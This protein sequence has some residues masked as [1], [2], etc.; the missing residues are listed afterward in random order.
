MSITGFSV[1]K[2]TTVFVLTIFV[3]IMGLISYFSMPRESAPDVKIPFMIVTTVYPGVAPADIENLITRRIE[4][5]LKGLSGVKEINSSSSESFSMI[6]IEFEPDVNLDVAL[7]KVKDKVDRA[8]PDLP[9]DAEDPIVTE[10]NIENFP[11]MTVN[12]TADYDL[13]KLRKV[14]KDLSDEFIT[15]P[16]VLDA[17]VS[18][19][20]EREVQINIDPERLKDYNLGLQDVTKTIINEHLTMPAGTMNIGDYGYTVRVPGELKDPEKFR[21]LVVKATKDGPVYI[22]DVADVRYGFKDLTTIARLDGK[23]CISINITKRSGENIININKEVN[24]ILKERGVSFPKGTH[25]TIQNDRSKEIKIMVADLENNIITGFILVVLCIFLFLGVTN[26]IFIG[27]AIPLSMLITFSVLQWMGITLN[28]IVLFSLVLAVGM[29]VDDAVVIVENIYRHRQNGQGKNESAVNATDE[30]F[31]AV[32][33]STVTTLVAFLPLLFWPGIIGEFMF[34]LPLTL[35]IALSAS[36]FVAFVMNPVFCAKFMKI[37]PKADNPFDP[38]STGLYARFL[39]RYEQLITH[40][41]HFPKTTLTLATFSL[42]LT[43]VLY[44]FYGHGVEFFPETDP[45]QLYIDIK[46]PIGQR[47]EATDAVTKQL[48]PVSK[49]FPD[50]T[51]VLADVGVST[52]ASG[53]SSGSGNPSNEARI[54]IDFADFDY[55][56]QH[57]LKTFNEAK[58]KI[59]FLAG[60]EVTLNKPEEGPPVGQAIDLRIS[61]D[62][63]L[64]LGD[65]A[66]DIRSKIKNVPGLVDLKD[67][68]ESSKPEIRVK[69]DREKAA[70]LELSTMDVAGAVRTAINGSEVSKYRVEE[71]EYDITVRFEEKYRKSIP[72]MDKIYVFKEGRQIPLSSVASFEPTAGFGTIHRTQ[73]KRVVDVTGQ[74]LGRLPNDIIIDIRK[75]LAN[76]E[77]PPGYGIA[78]AGADE[79]QR[80]AQAFLSKALLIAL[81]LITMVLV[82]HFDSIRIPLIIMSGV[83][84][85]FQG[86]MI[87]LLVHHMPFGVIMTGIGVISL[88]GVVVKNAIVILDFAERLRREGRSRAQAIIEAGKFRLRP[89]ILTALCT[90][91]GLI[92]MATGWSYDFHTF[93]FSVNGA[94]SQWWAPMAIAV[95]YGLG[96]STILTLV[97]VPSMYV[98]YT[99][100]GKAGA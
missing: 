2:S 67:D 57:T 90:I 92:P 71:D 49:A 37:N 94:S 86:V 9:P 44:G 5:E 41:V 31:M 55:R 74:N 59:Q 40:A 24:R 63:Y 88:A 82:G 81:F 43:F 12:L 25:V 7:Q 36:L 33:S 51:H 68:F 75:I 8:K 85:S 50:V 27:I 78:Y 70:I 93:T 62:D 77:L 73:L 61:G 98:L 65:I 96:V 48:E 39:R 53:L 52:G 58:G 4:K 32:T 29:L 23:P 3:V 30:V 21:D 11:I 34:Y 72:D 1:K 47:I 54:Y 87:G 18:G 19:D 28:F 15:I 69:V 80:K 99:K 22:R 64:L 35:I 14:A 100:D 17:I 97:I 60:Q 79:E 16:G 46:G 95:I 66:K 76:Y 13:V 38:K 26:S 84:L 83:I 10:V 56:K 6:S 42:L 20:L 45:D 89:V 91:A